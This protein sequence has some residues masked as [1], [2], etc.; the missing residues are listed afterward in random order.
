MGNTENHKT[1]QE[2]VADDVLAIAVAIKAQGGGKHTGEI[3][4]DAAVQA[5]GM[6]YCSELARHHWGEELKRKGIQM[7]EQVGK[8]RD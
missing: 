7:P 6:A 5:A 3:G 4:I 2:H 1:W 8:E